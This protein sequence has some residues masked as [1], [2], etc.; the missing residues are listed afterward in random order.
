MKSK[1]AILLH[2]LIITCTYYTLQRECIATMYEQEVEEVI[3]IEQEY[4]YAQSKIFVAKSI[5]I[6]FNDYQS[7]CSL[8]FLNDHAAFCP[9]RLFILYRK[10]II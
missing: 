3:S 8:S 6:I 7:F 5:Y 1:V 4:V 9:F 10:L 2:L